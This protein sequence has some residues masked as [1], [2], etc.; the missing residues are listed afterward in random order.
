MLFLKHRI[1]NV[2]NTE[3]LKY[4]G[5]SPE[6]DPILIGMGGTDGTATSPNM[7]EESGGNFDPEAWGNGLGSVLGGVG[8]L[9]GSLGIGG[10]NTGTNL[11]TNATNTGSNGGAPKSEDKRPNYTM[12]L[13]I[14]GVIILLVVGFI[15]LRKK[16]DN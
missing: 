13:I 15:L 12:W 1:M 10:N 11:P 9:L 8:D 5:Y 7:E 4:S 2:Y 6:T 16:G 14:I 3:Q